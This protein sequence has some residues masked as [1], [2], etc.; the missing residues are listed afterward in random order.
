MD[1]YPVIIFRPAILLNLKI[2]NLTTFN[3]GAD[4]ASTNDTSI[5]ISSTPYLR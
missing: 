2:P 4:V 5:S 3:R 1:F